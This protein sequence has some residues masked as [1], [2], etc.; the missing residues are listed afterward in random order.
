MTT[1]IDIP[2]TTV[3]AQVARRTEWQG[4]RSP[5]G[6]DYDRLALSESDKSLF[7]SFFD[8]AAMHAVDIC[9]PFLQ[10]VGNTDESLSMTLSLPEGSDHAGLGKTM[11]SMLTAHVL[12]LWQEIVAPQRAHDTFSRR[13]DFSL[14][15][16]S[17]LYHHQ[18]PRRKWR[19]ESGERREERGEGRAE[20]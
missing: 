18:A 6:R 16:Q 17:I 20:S 11:E 8:E 2:R 12:A 4:T 13:D 1:T 10:R 19:A 3:F 7:H 15:I 14:K 5:E 9:R